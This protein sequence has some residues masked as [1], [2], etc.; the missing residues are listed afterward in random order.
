M[1]KLFS[2]LV[3]IFFISTLQLS[4]QY[5]NSNSPNVANLK[6]GD[7]IFQVSTSGQGKAIQLAT[8]SKLTHCGIVFIENGV[9]IVYH[10]VD[11][12]QKTKAKDFIARG[13][14]GKYWVKRLNRKLSDEEIKK[15]KE[16]AVL[17][18]GKRYDLRFMWSDNK[19]YCSEYVW[20]IYNK[21]T[22]ISVGSP[23]KLKEYS[24]DNPIT[25]GI[26]KKRYGK[27]VPWEESMISP[28]DI[29]SCKELVNTN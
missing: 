20:K 22:G 13:E 18:L 15:M 23:K 2:I 6:N 17:Q 9:P 16:Y 12:V 24:T 27:N 1:K 28:G 3:G 7:V 25:Q 26:M 14:N 29:F 5:S 21:G 8:G 10:A 19:M 4:C 11:P